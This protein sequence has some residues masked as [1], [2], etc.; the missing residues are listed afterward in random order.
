MAYRILFSGLMVFV[1]HHDNGNA[2]Y[3]ACDQVDVL[4]LN[5]CA[6]HEAGNHD[7]ATCPDHHEP[8]LIVKSSDIADWR[9][10]GVLQG[11]GSH[12]FDV[13]GKTVFPRIGDNRPIQLPTPEFDEFAVDPFGAMQHVPFLGGI[14]D[15]E[16]VL[17]PGSGRINPLFQAPDPN[18]ADFRRMIVAKV[19]L[20][21]GRLTAL[22]PLANSARSLIGWDVGDQKLEFLAEMAMFEPNDQADLRIALA[23][24]VEHDQNDFVA[25]RRN[26]DVTVWITNEP[27]RGIRARGAELI[28]AEHFKH[29]YDLLAPHLVPP[30]V[31]ATA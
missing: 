31:G 5:P 25:L 19:R 8:Q 22:A 27:R 6:L 17:G 4:L 24:P 12:H 29:Y 16:K 11:C 13:E 7:E 3:Q 30:A 14:V 9:L 15:M 23:P 28:E 2:E 18:P 26:R 1:E 21:A 10:A 20:P